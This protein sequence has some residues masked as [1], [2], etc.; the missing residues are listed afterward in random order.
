[1]ASKYKGDPATNH[2]MK[3]YLKIIQD[4]DPDLKKFAIESMRQEIRM[5]TSSITTVVPKPLKFLH[6][7]YEALKSCYEV[8]ADSELK[9]YLA[10]VLSVVAWSISAQGE[11]EILKYRLLGSEGDIGSWGHGYVRN[12]ADEILEEFE[13]PEIEVSPISDLMTL[14]G[15]IVAFLMKHNAEPEAIDLLI[16]VG[17]LDMLLDHVESTNYKRTCWHLASATRYVDMDVLDIACNIYEIYGDYTSALRFILFQDDAKKLK[18]IIAS[19]DDALHK[20]QFCYML[21]RHG[22]TLELDEKMVPNENDR[23]VS[24]D[25]INNVKLSEGYLMLARVIDAME[26]KSHKEICNVHLA[27]DCRS[28]ADIARMHVAATFMNAFVNAGFGQ[29]KLMTSGSESTRSWLFR[30]KKHRKTSVAASLGLILLWDVDAGLAQIEKYFDSNDNHVIAGALLAVGIITCG[31]KDDSDPA[32]DLLANY[33][34]EEDASIR[35]GAIMGLGIAYAGSQ[36][37]RIDSLLSPILEDLTAP[38]DVLAFTAISLGLV[39]VGSGNQKVINSIISSITM[40]RSEAELSNPLIR[41]LPLGVGLVYLGKKDSCERTANVTVVAFFYQVNVMDTLSG[42]SRD[43]DSE[44]A[45]CAIISLGLIGA[46][47]NNAQIASMLH[48]LA[49]HYSKEG[50]LLFCVRIAQG[51]LHLGKG[52]L[53][54]SPYHSNHLLLSPT[55]LAGI[56][57]MLCACLDMKS[58]IL[59]D[60]PYV[61]YFL[62]LAMQPRMLMTLGENLEPLAVAVRVGQTVRTYS[63]PVVLAAEPAELLTENISDCRYIP[64]SPVLEDFVILKENPHYLEEH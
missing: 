43:T 15:Q 26:P 53:T 18:E 4:L 44:V 39:F 32:L 64:L 7:H 63:T 27:F 8:M 3:Q 24:Q 28:T 21:A 59:G 45:M 41:F 36:N 22:V 62:V 34:N 42:L 61:L 56:I 38:L 57:T 52:L 35:I 47:T 50:S 11:Q 17:C 9:K 33:I 55:R 60:Y 46:G 37:G 10:D 40:D 51:L 23:K 13:K 14:V 29:D 19:F 58:I 2:R 5:L 48:G 49:K 30:N 54:L 16:K 1:M 31:I 25:I 12:L 6:P 20:K